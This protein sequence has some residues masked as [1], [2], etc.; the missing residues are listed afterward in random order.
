ML[1]EALWGAYA[2]PTAITPP[3]CVRA[4][5]LQ[6]WLA[7]SQVSA[8]GPDEE[9]NRG[10]TRVALNLASLTQN[11]A[12]VHARETFPPAI[13]DQFKGFS[14]RELIAHQH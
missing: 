7:D 5:P 3:H 11:V 2:L 12:S 13:L 6:Q 4:A 10:L 14:H 1:E 8:I 9:L